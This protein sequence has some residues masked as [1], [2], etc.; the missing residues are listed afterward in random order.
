MET[1]ETEDRHLDEDDGMD[2]TVGHNFNSETTCLIC[3]TFMEPEK[4][5][6]LGDKA[7]ETVIAASKKRND[8]K[9]EIIGKYGTLKLHKSC[10]TNYIN[11]SNIDAA[12][13]KSKV[14]KQS[15]RAAV[16]VAK[17]FDFESACY[18]CTSARHPRNKDIYFVKN[19]E[20]VIGVAEA[21]KAR[22]NLSEDDALLLQRVNTLKT[23][24]NST[25]AIYHG[26]CYKKFYNYRVNS[27]LGRPLSEDMANVLSFIIK[28][29]LKHTDECQFSVQSILNNYDRN[30]SIDL[31]EIK[32]IIF[33]ITLATTYR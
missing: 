2:V 19:I 31:R 11:S 29:I 20:K 1:E 32:K 3:F 23:K 17:E 13:K 7:R 10:Y 24:F 28:Y 14:Q 6:T 21:L 26:M 5:R 25:K 8:S 12:L 30:K 15:W 18:F 16:Q 9:H 33:K 27:I 22:E 4:S